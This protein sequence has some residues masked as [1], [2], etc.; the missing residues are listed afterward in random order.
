[1][2][3]SRDK[4][5]NYPSIVLPPSHSLCR[6]SREIAGSVSPNFSLGRGYVVQLSHEIVIT[7]PQP[8]PLLPSSPPQR[9]LT[10]RWA[11]V[12]FKAAR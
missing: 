7:S 1:M 2:H 10:L 9:P 6:I 8:H 3:N 11:Y 5:D 4:T 12:V